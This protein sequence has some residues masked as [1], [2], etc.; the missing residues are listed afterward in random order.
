MALYATIN[1]F[2]IVCYSEKQDTQKDYPF[3]DINH[4]F[5]YSCQLVAPAS[6]AKL[7]SLDSSATAGATGC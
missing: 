7:A 2:T 4:P 6:D 1:S 3:H 5:R